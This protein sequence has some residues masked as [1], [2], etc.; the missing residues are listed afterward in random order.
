MIEIEHG[1]H[2]A[3]TTEQAQTRRDYLDTV[4]AAIP[5]EPFTAEMARIA[6][7]IDAE[8]RQARRVI[9]LADLLI[10][11]AAPPAATRSRTAQATASG[12]NPGLA[13]ACGRAGA[14]RPRWSGGEPVLPILASPR[15]PVQAIF[16]GYGATWIYSYAC[17]SRVTDCGRP[18]EM[19]RALPIVSRSGSLS[20]PHAPFLNRLCLSTAC[21]RTPLNRAAERRLAAP[22]P[23]TPSDARCAT[24]TLIQ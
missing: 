11:A 5:V 7:K 18:R 17:D 3:Q 10:G 8:A 21:R 4:I 1:L 6:A 16:R 22:C 13:T 14:C 23:R 15:V 2:R 12:P 24:S 20:P 19:R 9:P